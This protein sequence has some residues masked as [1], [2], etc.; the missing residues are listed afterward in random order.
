M[1]LE[2]VSDE[3]ALAEVV[4][5]SQA[6]GAPFGVPVERFKSQQPRRGAYQASKKGLVQSLHQVANAKHGGSKVPESLHYDVQI[7][8]HAVQSLTSA[9]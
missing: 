9:A 6:F 3:G 5:T 2:V 4:E 8:Q 1:A 7:V